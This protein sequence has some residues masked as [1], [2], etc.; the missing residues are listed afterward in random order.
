MRK[1]NVTIYNEFHHEQHKPH[2]AAIYPNG[3][4]G[5]IVEGLA[6]DDLGEIV[7]AT[8]DDHIAVLT[9]ACLDNTD[10]LIWWGHGKHAMVDD[11]VVDMVCARVNEG[12]GFLPL[13]SAHASKP[14]KRLLGTNANQLRWREA[15][16]RCRV[17]TVAQNH[18]ITAGLE[19][20]FVVPR[21]EMYGE[22]FG[23]PEPDEL[24][25]I[26]W[27]EGGDVFR[28][29]CTWKRGAGK[30]FYFQNGHE[31]YPVYYQT[32]VRRVIHNGIRWVCPEQRSYQAYPDGQ[33]FPVMLEGPKAGLTE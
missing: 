20:S 11:G 1:I 23:I 32:E 4:H 19:A 28:S 16:E 18:P 26:S 6:G 5:A 29:G 3:I 33:H 25:F 8:L 30:I 13:H 22:A 21:E 12:M 31:S 2:I 27:F 24:I 10:V 15:G 17:W 7:C 9:Q 14:M